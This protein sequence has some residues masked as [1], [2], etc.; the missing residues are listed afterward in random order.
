[1]RSGEAFDGRDAEIIALRDRGQTLLREL[2]RYKAGDTLHHEIC[3]ELFEHLGP[4][5]IVSTPFC[6]EFGSNIRI[7]THSYLNF[8]VTLLDVGP[9][10]IG[11]NVMIAPNVQIYTATHDE[12]ALLRRSWAVYGKA[13]TIGDDVWIGGGAIICPGVTIGPRC[14]IGAGAVV[15]RDIPADSVAVGNPARVVRQVQSHEASSANDG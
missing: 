8:N 14:I 5:S 9:I 15:T 11:D 4:G 1:M 13:V 2:N 7:G 6:C 10:V 3:G 12:D